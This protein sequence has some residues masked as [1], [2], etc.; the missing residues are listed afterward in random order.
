MIR[1]KFAIFSIIAY[2]VLIF[3]YFAYKDPRVENDECAFEKTCARFCCNDKK[4]CNT[5]TIRANFNL[6]QKE[7][8][9]ILFGEPNCISMAPLDREW[10]FEVMA[11]ERRK[12]VNILLS[13]FFLSTETFGQHRNQRANLHITD[14]ITFAS[15]ETLTLMKS[16]NGTSNFVMTKKLES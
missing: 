12:E 5:S 10:K 11:C 3:S 4:L 13:Y 7:S 9:V 6:A 8:F 1:K 16:L 14:T 2:L 15:K